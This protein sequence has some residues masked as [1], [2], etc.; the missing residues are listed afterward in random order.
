MAYTLGR[1]GFSVSAGGA[2]SQWF[3]FDEFASIAEVVSETRIWSVAGDAVPWVG[4]ALP[5]TGQIRIRQGG[6]STATKAIRWPYNLGARIGAS[7]G[8]NPGEL[9]VP[10]SFDATADGRVFVLDAGNDRIQAFDLEG[11]YITHWV[12][13][14]GAGGVFDFGNGH[15]IENFVGSIAIDDEGFIYVADVGNGQIQKFAP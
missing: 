15:A 9:F 4:M 2:E 5:Q 3:E 12:G 1:N 6:F 10:L 7:L 13:R 11:N 14:E 8:S